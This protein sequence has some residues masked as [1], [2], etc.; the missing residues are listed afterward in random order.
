MYT[1]RYCRQTTYFHIAICLQHERR[2]AVSRQQPD[3]AA[4]YPMTTPVDNSQQVSHINRYIRND[5]GS[6]SCR[7]RSFG[8][9]TIQQ[10]SCYFSALSLY[11]LQLT[12]HRGTEQQRQRSLGWKVAPAAASDSCNAIS[13]MPHTQIGRPGES[14]RSRS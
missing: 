1:L 14:A 12:R 10:L 5:V 3:R 9:L 8:T 7:Q 2:V 13:T 11:C 4:R 6:H